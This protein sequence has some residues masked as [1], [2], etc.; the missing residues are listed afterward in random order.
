[1]PF[2]MLQ[3]LPVIVF[4]SCVISILYHWGVMQTLISGIAWVMEKT[5]ST[6][7]TESLT[8]ASNIFVGQV[9]S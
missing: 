5:L 8:A 2:C 6:A 7:A 3:I 9:D 4:F 1:M